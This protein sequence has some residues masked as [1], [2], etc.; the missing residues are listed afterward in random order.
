MSFFYSFKERIFLFSFLSQFVILQSA[1]AQITYEMPTQEPSLQMCAASSK[2]FTFKIK[3]GNAPSDSFSLL[4]NL[5]YK[6]TK[7]I[8]QSGGLF[9][10]SPDT[11]NPKVSFPGFVT[12]TAF[13]PIHISG[14]DSAEVITFTV[15]ARAGC[16]VDNGGQ[17]FITGY[18]ELIST[19]A[20]SPFTLLKQ[21]VTVSGTLSAPTSRDASWSQTATKGQLVTRTFVYSNSSGHD[22]S[23]HISFHD[24]LTGTVLRDSLIEVFIDGNLD[25]TYYN[26]NSFLLSNIR[27]QKNIG[28]LIIK[29]TALV[30]NCIAKGTDGHSDVTISTGCLDFESC[31]SDTFTLD[32]FPAGHP[33]IHKEPLTTWDSYF[34]CFGGGYESR[35]ASFKNTGAYAPNVNITFVPATG[36]ITD[37]SSFK[38]SITGGTK[39]RGGNFYRNPL[40]SISFADLNVLGGT[41]YGPYNNNSEVGTLSF[42][43]DLI[44]PFAGY[45]CNDNNYLWSRVINHFTDSSGIHAIDLDSGET[46]TISWQDKSCCFDQNKVI[47]APSRFDLP[48]LH[49]FYPNC[50]NIMVDSADY[51]GYDY[52]QGIQKIDPFNVM[53]DGNPDKCILTNDGQI[54]DFRIRN[55]NV[56]RP[57]WIKNDTATWGNFVMDLN[58]EPGVDLDLSLMGSAMT[59]AY[60][61]S[62]CGFANCGTSSCPFPLWDT[63]TTST[64]PRYRIR[65]HHSTYGD[66]N[67]TIT[68]L[69]VS[70]SLHKK[71]RITF[72]LDS[73]PGHPT[74]INQ[75]STIF[76]GMTLDYSLR[77]Y[78]GGGPR[79]NIFANLRGQTE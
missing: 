38:I 7:G 25:T 73:M 46:I 57:A 37:P 66:W 41:V 42:Y 29:E 58:M 43:K 15:Q 77:S 69:P 19:S 55:I 51:S 22:F 31:H 68:S 11:T 61:D 65:F 78:C 12:N 74:D 4:L 9:L 76:N 71:Y 48:T 63:T 10:S 30:Q 49:F 21:D 56:G 17:S 5:N 40:D 39:T 20:E 3:N 53:V 16:G 18:A 6:D 60:D 70:G 62:T 36:Y 72:N 27:V 23:G 32:V 35:Q 33:S 54:R 79:T 13:L 26:T 67:G 47:A 59:E 52:N 44:G 14:M 24:N 34:Q 64:T 45:A 50:Q 28:K 1:F 2:T 8:I 75:M